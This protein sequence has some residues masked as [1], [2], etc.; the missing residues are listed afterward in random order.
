MSQPLTEEELEKFRAFAK[1]LSNEDPAKRAEEDKW[2][3]AAVD[4][5]REAFADVDNATLARFA[6]AV[7]YIMAKFEKMTVCEMHVA[8]ENMF[9]EYG[10]AG[11]VLAGFYEPDAET[12]KHSSGLLPTSA[13]A[14][15]SSPGT[16]E[17]QNVGM[18]L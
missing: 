17:A 16:D 3:L 13:R 1:M 15:Q 14:T 6:N 2:V 8:L 10:L 7:A 18:F 11:C 12:P 9:L 4:A 5:L